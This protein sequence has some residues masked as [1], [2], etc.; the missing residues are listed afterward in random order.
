[1][2]GVQDCWSFSC[3]V[4]KTLQQSIDTAPS[5]PPGPIGACKEPQAY[6]F[7]QLINQLT[8][9]NTPC[10]IAARDRTTIGSEQIAPS[11]LG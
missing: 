3:T 2:N 6:V 7:I 5:G 11:S 4:G 1:M 10:T 9:R 8:A